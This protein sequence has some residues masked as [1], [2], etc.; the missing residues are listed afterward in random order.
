Y[1]AATRARQTWNH[2]VVDRAQGR[3]VL[4]YGCSEGAHSLVRLEIHRIAREFHGIDVSDQAIDRAR[5]TAAAPGA[6]NASFHVMDA[7][8]L[9]F[10]DQSFDL[11]FGRGIL[12]HLDVG[13]SFAELRRVLRPGGAAVF[14]E[15]MGHNP[16]IN[17]F[18]RRTPSMRTPDEHPLVMAD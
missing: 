16:L 8:R 6:A 18:R 9:A 11:I 14:L 17:A 2:L 1:A 5:R 12:H 7:A 4:E 3:T 10:P 15:P 13:A